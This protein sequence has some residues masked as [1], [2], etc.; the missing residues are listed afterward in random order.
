MSTI[1]NVTWWDRDIIE[2]VGVVNGF[3]H[4][5]SCWRGC[6]VCAPGGGHL[7]FATGKV[8][9]GIT[10]ALFILCGF[11]QHRCSF[12]PRIFAL[13]MFCEHGRLVACRSLGS[14]WRTKL[15]VFSYSRASM[16]L[17]P[18]AFLAMPWSGCWMSRLYCSWLCRQWNPLKRLLTRKRHP[19][20]S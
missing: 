9:V 15:S 6:S 14:L 18:S 11:Y 10:N 1:P 16:V 5:P 3:P 17:K 13:C 20:S 8:D 19:N 4:Y 12:F 2:G 7:G